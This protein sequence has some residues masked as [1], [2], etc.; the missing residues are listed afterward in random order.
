MALPVRA[1]GRG[2]FKKMIVYKCDRC[3]KILSTDQHNIFAVEVIPPKVWTYFEGPI[4]YPSGEYH[5][6]ANCI[7]KIMECVDELGRSRKE[8]TK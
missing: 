1:S 7:E 2:G 8:T 4:K 3:G 6:C 5:F